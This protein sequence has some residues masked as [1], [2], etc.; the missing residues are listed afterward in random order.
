MTYRDYMIGSN[1]N[2]SWCK[3]IEGWSNLKRIRRKRSAHSNI[4]G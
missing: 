4:M 3:P 2:L 1:E